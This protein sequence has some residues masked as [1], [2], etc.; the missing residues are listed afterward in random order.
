MKAAIFHAMVATMVAAA[1]PP[2]SDMPGYAQGLLSIVGFDYD[3]ECAPKVGNVTIST[4]MWSKIS[5]HC[6]PVS[7]ATASVLSAKVHF[8]EVGCESKFEFMKLVN[9]S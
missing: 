2:V 7:S 9:I 4:G 5:E 8:L 3:T 6:S 1:P